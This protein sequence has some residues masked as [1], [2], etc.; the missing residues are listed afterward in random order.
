M[1]ER[2]M[3][4]WLVLTVT[5]A[6]LAAQAPATD[7]TSRE[8]FAH[9]RAGQDQLGA[10]R[11]LR[12]RTLWPWAGIH[13]RPPHT[14]RRVTG[15]NSGP[16]EPAAG[17]LLALGSA[18]FRNGHRDEAEHH[19]SEATKASPRLGEAWNNRAVVHLQTA[20]KAEATNAV[21]RAGKAASVCIGNSRTI[22]PVCRV[23]DPGAQRL[24]AP[25]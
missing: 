11:T 1:R 25:A 7:A 13:G 21:E 9:Y 5:L 10:R 17:V 19:W 14:V 3:V 16:F 4:N 23:G 20:R 2:W 12:R 24:P 22:S 18:H 15:H 6:P 8:A